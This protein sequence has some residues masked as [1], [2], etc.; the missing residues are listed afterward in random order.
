[1]KEITVEARAEN[2]EEVTEFVNGQLRAFGCPAKTQA[3]I[4]VAVDELFGNIAHYAYGTGKGPATVRVELREQPPA[5]VL[6]FLDRGMP[7]DPLMRQD[8][9]T[10]LSAE[11]RNIGGLG[12]YM[13]KKMMDEVSYDYRGG[14]NILTV[15]K[16]I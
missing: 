1:M 4:D 6:T 11:E 16:K 8:P 10:T 3:Q 2:I 15:V 5:V 13:V 12:V 9:D 14:Q 7:Y